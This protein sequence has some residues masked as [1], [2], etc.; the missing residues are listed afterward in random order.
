[1]PSG[2]DAGSARESDAAC[3]GDH[4]PATVRPAY[5]VFVLDRSNSMQQSHKWEECSAALESFFEDPS[6]AGLSASVTVLPFVATNTS[7][8][9]CTAAD[10]VTPEVPMSALPSAAFGTLSLIELRRGRALEAL[11][12]SERG[13]VAEL[14]T[15]S[16]STGS[17]LYLARAEALYSLGRLDEARA[18]IGEAR[19]RV[20]RIAG[21]LDGEPELRESYLTEIDA[22]ARTLLLASEWLG[23]Q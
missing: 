23:A 22:N 17:S 9:S 12:F 7:A 16:A 18:A 5:L 19:D 21:T 14:R 2:P 6:T 3:A 1:M 10:Y 8:A 13:L 11:E 15:P 20:L 4:V